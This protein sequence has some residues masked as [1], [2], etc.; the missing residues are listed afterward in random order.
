MTMPDLNVGLITTTPCTV[1]VAGQVQAN[2][3]VEWVELCTGLTP[4]RAR[5]SFA[6]PPGGIYPP[7]TLNADFGAG[8][9]WGVLKFGARVE[10]IHNDHIVFMGMLHRQRQ[11]NDGRT[12][13][14][15][16]E[17][18][19][20]KWLLQRIPVRG[21]LVRDPAD[22]T[23]VKFISRY[24]PHFNPN[25]D[26]NCIGAS[27]TVAGSTVIVP[28]FSDIAV[29][30]AT[31]QSPSV[32]FP[33]ALSASA[34]YRAAITA[35]TPRRVLQY[36]CVLSYLSV[37]RSVEGEGA[38]AVT[39]DTPDVPGLRYEHWRSIRHSQRLIWPLSNIDAITDKDPAAD[40]G[41]FDRKFPDA[42]F[43]GMNLAQ[44]LDQ[45][46][47]ISGTHGWHLTYGEITEGEGEEAVTRNTSV[48]NYHQIGYT[49]YTSDAPGI[50]LPLQ[51]GGQPLVKNG[52]VVL[53]Y[54]VDAD[55]DAISDA[56]LIE[57]DVRRVETRLTYDGD[58]E[59][60]T[61]VPAWT[62][63]EESM[64]R[65]IIN[66]GTGTNAE[67]R[68][69]PDTWAKTPNLT[70]DPVT[71]ADCNG[72]DG[73]PKIQPHTPEA[74]AHARG[75]FPRVFRTFRVVSA[76][77]TEALGGVHAPP[78]PGE[79]T[80]LTKYPSLIGSNRPIM[81][82]QLQF[83][84]EKTDTGTAWTRSYLPV[85]IEVKGEYDPDWMDV[86]FV[87]LSVSGDGLLW[88]DSI[89]ESAE[90]R[91][92]CLYEKTFCSSDPDPMR[93]A[94]K[95]LRIN[96]AM[97]MDHR[98]AEYSEN[99]SGSIDTALRT[100]LGGPVLHYIDAGNSFFEHH[101][102][103][104]HPSPRNAM[105]GGEAGI[106]VVTMP[107]TRFVP[108]GSEYKHAQYA[109]T[110]ALWKRRIIHN[111]SVWT[112]LGIRTGYTPGAWLSG[113]VHFAPLKP[114]DIDG[115]MLLTSD[116]ATSGD[117]RAVLGNGNATIGAALSIGAPIQAV[118]YDFRQHKTFLSGVEAGGE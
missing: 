66:G 56:V 69:L 72:V 15:V 44:A 99:L 24:E 82:Q 21:A 10:I 19:D 112:I 18:V 55:I 26:W 32:V 106:D 12:E 76:K 96:A 80:D 61:I 63:D 60:D 36:L 77:L 13:V 71:W 4:G 59:T 104:S 102:V 94:L 65:Q 3:D 30:G 108:P 115:V 101:Q 25:G 117:Y 67:G 83:L 92:E 17:C 5:I 73:R 118:R 95:R 28:V 20:D 42:N 100:E 51:R 34:D 91:K 49:R 2:A 39:T 74:L 110:R 111:A 45:T 93:V 16:W 58:A 11:S 81:M 113:I 85:R 48:V 40:F 105:F 88:L 57:G 6:P 109:A 87:S 79:Y 98:L 7:Q 78:L 37:S 97:P 84:S 38:G 114:F 35:W 52:H 54:E 103:N 22:A 53:A 1:K 68:S 43:R 9:G 46:L 89:C 27:V 107:L 50:M 116:P 23:G 62:D 29:R 90:G 41:P 8:T 70:A 31:Y 14:N 75:I 47:S 33:E 86:G 64:F